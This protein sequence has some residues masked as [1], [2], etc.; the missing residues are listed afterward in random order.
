MTFKRLAVVFLILAL[1]LVYIF[2]NPSEVDFLPKCPFYLA[3]GFYCAG[4]GSQRATHQLLNLNFNGVIQQNIFYVFVLILVAYHL[5]ITIINKI[6]KKKIYN[7]LYHPKVPMLFLV[8]IIL[9][10][11]MRNI[12]VYPF[13]LLAPK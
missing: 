5:M 13:N 1:I 2:I 6:F 3:T 4:C 11:V 12:P 9:F 7:L 10:W 8:V